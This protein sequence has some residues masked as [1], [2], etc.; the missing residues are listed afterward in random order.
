MLL[1]SPRDVE[2][3]DL[4]LKQL[5]LGN[6][7]PKWYADATSIPYGHILIDLSPKTKD[8]LRYSTDITLFQTKL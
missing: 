7:L 4:Q 3:I 8:L 2:Q 6:T 5:R 1:K